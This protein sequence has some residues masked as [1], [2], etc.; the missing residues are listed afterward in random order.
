MASGVPQL[1]SLA[2]PLALARL[3]ILIVPVGPSLTKA[4]FDH[5]T[6]VIRQFK[7]IRVGDLPDL[8]TARGTK[9]EHVLPIRVQADDLHSE[10][11][12]CSSPTT[13]EPPSPFIPVSSYTKV[14]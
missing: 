6:K 13:S 9:G 1:S 11:L 10:I 7:D 2:D 3:Q 5:W 4:T 8:A 12:A 14:N